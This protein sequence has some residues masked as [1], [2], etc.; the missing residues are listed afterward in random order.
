VSTAGTRAGPTAPSAPGREDPVVE[1]AL[2]D[3]AGVIVSVNDA[4]TAFAESNGGD[5]RRTG[6]GVSYLSACAAAPD[7]PFAAQAAAAVRTALSGDLPAPFRAV[8]PCHAPGTSRWFDVLVSSRFDDRGRCVGAT[9][10]LSLAVSTPVRPADAAVDAAG[11]R[12]SGSALRDRR[13]RPPPSG[14]AAAAF[15]ADRSERFGD[16]FAQV[17]FDRAPLG[18]LVVDDRGVVVRAGRAVEELLGFGPDALDGVPVDALLVGRVPGE[19][20]PPGGPTAAFGV[21]ADGATVGLEVRSGPIHL[22]RGCGTVLLVRE[23]GPPGAGPVGSGPDDTRD[24]LDL[25]DEVARRG[26]ACGLRL[27]GLERAGTGGPTDDVRAAAD[28]VDAMLRAARAVALW[29]HEA[30]RPGSK[31]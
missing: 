12:I 10:T 11:G 2:L 26:L 4:W 9:V 13:R 16:E 23:A 24:L 18:I 17:L 1:V 3:T 20:V 8:V 29:L 31:L 7:D 25:L 14:P 21:R 19:P 27:E 15:Y 5:P 28:D 6:V 30:H 22:S